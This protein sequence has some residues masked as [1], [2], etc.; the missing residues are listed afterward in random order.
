MTTHDTH[1]DPLTQLDE[2][3][4]LRAE[5]Q[6]IHDETDKLLRAQADQ[7]QQQAMAAHGRAWSKPVEV[8]ALLHIAHKKGIKLTPEHLDGLERMAVAAF[9]AMDIM[10]DDMG[11]RVMQTSPECH[12]AVRAWSAKM[13]QTMGKLGACVARM[14]QSFS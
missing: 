6:A 12:Q 1:Q 13:E 8:L 10:L 11:K 3:L 2:L 9:D 14:Q 4:T 5:T 7:A